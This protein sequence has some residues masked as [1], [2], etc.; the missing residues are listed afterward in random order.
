MSERMLPKLSFNGSSLRLPLIIARWGCPNIVGVRYSIPYSIH[1]PPHQ[2]AVCT[3]EGC[4]KRI[5]ER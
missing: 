5:V 1:I 2:Y 4:I 3:S